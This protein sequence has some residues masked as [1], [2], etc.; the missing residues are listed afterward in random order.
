MIRRPVLEWSGGKVLVG[1][2]PDDYVKISNKP[3]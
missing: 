2:K 3:K 1:F